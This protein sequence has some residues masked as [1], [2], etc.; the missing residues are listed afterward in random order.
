M[1]DWRRIQSKAIWRLTPTK[2]GNSQF[3][4]EV[5]ARGP[6]ELAPALFV[7]NTGE[8][9]T[10]GATRGVVWGEQRRRTIW[11]QMMGFEC[12][13]RTALLLTNTHIACYT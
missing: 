11:R 1:V 10:A 13:L 6:T 2:K 3:L 12:S 4:L 8:S 9:S 5:D 7:T